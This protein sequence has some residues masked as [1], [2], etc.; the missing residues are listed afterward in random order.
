[1]QN[2]LDNKPEVTHF[3]REQIL[4]KIG[5]HGATA[6]P[7]TV[8]GEKD[9]LDDGRRAVCKVDLGL[10]ELFEAIEGRLGDREW[11][12]YLE[13]KYQDIVI[14]I[15]CDYEQYRRAK[16]YNPVTSEHE[17]IG[18]VPKKFRPKEDDVA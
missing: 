8:K 3:T 6:H 13:D 17:W 16:L 12:A 10:S 5:L 11:L 14:H 4:D 18:E 15:N 2:D 7:R 9:A 1:M